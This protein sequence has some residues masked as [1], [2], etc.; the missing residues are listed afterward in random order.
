M[1]LSEFVITFILK[2]MV[3]YIRMYDT[4][5]NYQDK[6]KSYKSFHTVVV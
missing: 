1:R 5:L 4:K 6:K 3:I 2:C